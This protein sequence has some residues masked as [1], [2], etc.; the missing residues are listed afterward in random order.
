VAL[1]LIPVAT[2]LLEALHRV[3]VQEALALIQAVAVVAK[4]EILLVLEQTEQA[5]PA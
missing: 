2:R 1:G 3:R 4:E 5:A